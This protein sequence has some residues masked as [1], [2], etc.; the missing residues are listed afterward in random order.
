MYRGQ[1]PGSRQLGS[2][3]YH[4]PVSVSLP[5]LS[6]LPSRLRR[7]SPYS[8]RLSASRVIVTVTVP[9][10]RY[11]A[12]DQQFPVNL[13]HIH[14]IHTRLVA[15]TLPSPPLR[16]LSAPLFTSSLAP[17]ISVVCS[18]APRHHHS[19]WPFALLCFVSSTFTFNLSP[20]PL[21]PPTFTNLPNGYPRRHCGR[22]DHHSDCS[23]PDLG[24]RST[25][26]HQLGHHHA[27][28]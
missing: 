16:P 14:P 20:F 2:S 5:S 25:V 27:L 7:N 12:S 15:S 8:T 19:L 22:S 3:I 23:E 9:V 28:K 10:T 13:H 11:F 1:R 24:P 26:S 17:P 6:S 18:F 4:R 21:A